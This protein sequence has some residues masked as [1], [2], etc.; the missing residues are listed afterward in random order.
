MAM[1]QCD[2]HGLQGV[3]G[4]C[5][6]PCMLLCNDCLIKWDR[7]ITEE[8]KEEFVDTLSIICGPCFDAWN[9]KHNEV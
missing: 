9:K 1:I 8:D 2:I 3:C 4:M 7:L 5:I 6:L